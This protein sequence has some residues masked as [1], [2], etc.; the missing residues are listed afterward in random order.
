MPIS[1]IVR[2]KGDYRDDR[3]RELRKEGIPLLKKHGATSHR[4]GFYQSGGHAG[5]ILIVLGYPDLAAHERAMK[6]MSQDADWQRV[7]AAVEKIAPLQETY[8]V[9]IT[10]EN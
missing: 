5:E 1:M 10:E 4:F 2:R 9:V 7:A 8:L 3:L 6:G